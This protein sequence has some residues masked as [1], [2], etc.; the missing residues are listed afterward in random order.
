MSLCFEERCSL[1]FLGF[2]V[3]KSLKAVWKE[4]ISKPITGERQVQL[5]Q[6][7]SQ[8][9]TLPLFP[10][11]HK[12]SAKQQKQEAA[13]KPGG[14]CKGDIMWQETLQ[15]P[16]LMKWLISHYSPNN[17]GTLQWAQRAAFH[18]PTRNLVVSLRRKG[19]I[20][21]RL[22]PR[23]HKEWASKSGRLVLD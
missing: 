8:K 6:E 4:H 13:N 3:I 9:I 5:S 12:E 23:D 16:W 1:W 15:S 18:D 17:A 19:L 14:Q 11:P 2:V 21:F 22:K 10:A 20:I 7:P